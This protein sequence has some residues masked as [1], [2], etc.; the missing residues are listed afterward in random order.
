MKKGGGPHGRGMGGGGE[1]CLQVV[2]RFQAERGKERLFQAEKGQDCFRMP[3]GLTFSSGQDAGVEA[4]FVGPAG[5]H[6]Q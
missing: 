4:L 1:G 5:V 3:L 6:A 2:L